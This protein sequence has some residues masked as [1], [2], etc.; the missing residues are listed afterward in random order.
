MG[1]LAKMPMLRS[2]AASLSTGVMLHGCGSGGGSAPAIPIEILT[3]AGENVIQ[4]DA[5]A[6][7]VGAAGAYTFTEGPV[8]VPAPHNLWIWSEIIGNRMYQYDGSAVTDFRNPSNRTNGNLWHN[9]KLLSCEHIGRAVVY[10][11]VPFAEDT[12]VEIVSEFNNS[13]LNSPNDIVIGK[14]GAF[15][16]SDPAYGASPDYGHGLPLEQYSK[17]L[18]RYDEATGDL[19][20]LWSAEGAGFVGEQPNGVAFND[21]FTKLYLADSGDVSKI[22]VFD[23]AVDGLSLSNEQEFARCSEGLADGMKMDSLGNLWV[24]CGGGVEV[25]ATDGT[26]IVKINTGRATN[27]AFGGVDGQSLMITATETVWIVET[28]VTAVV[29]VAEDVASV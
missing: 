28:L 9:G 27:L 12:R 29:P 4:V 23:V 3:A 16:F 18:Y 10:Q 2:L 24:G 15:Y 5:N 14:G 7:T 6:M 13:K 19:R 21:D 20:S 1:V 17:N 11:E 22:M 25:F 8:W 26:R